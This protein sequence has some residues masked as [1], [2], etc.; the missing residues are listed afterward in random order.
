MEIFTLAL[1]IIIDEI[2]KMNLYK[3]VKIQLRINECLEIMLVKFYLL[4]K[5]GFETIEI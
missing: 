3:T 4:L 1:L 2:S 5:N